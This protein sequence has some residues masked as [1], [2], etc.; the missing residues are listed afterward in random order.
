MIIN[1]QLNFC[2]GL[3]GSLSDDRVLWQA[4]DIHRD[5][6]H[7][8]GKK[9][10]F[11]LGVFPNDIYGHLFIYDLYDHPDSLDWSQL[12]QK[13]VSGFSRGERRFA[14]EFS[15]NLKDKTKILSKYFCHIFIKIVITILSS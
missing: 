1:N 4:S 8:G 7:D 10:C 15:L 3:H 11:S 2:P 5:G 9:T 14:C 12:N 13:L 6:K